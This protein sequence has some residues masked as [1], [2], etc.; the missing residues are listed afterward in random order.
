MKLKLVT[1]E[2]HQRKVLAFQFLSVAVRFAE[3]GT[4]ARSIRICKK[5]ILEMRD[6]YDRALLLSTRAAF[7]L[8]DCRAFDSGGAYVE[9]SFNTLTDR[10]YGLGTQVSDVDDL[11]LPLID[12][13]PMWGNSGR[14]EIISGA[15]FAG[16]VVRR[17]LAKI[18]NTPYLPPFRSASPAYPGPFP[19]PR[20]SALGTNEPPLDPTVSLREDRD[21]CKG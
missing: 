9:S 7:T 1:L 19:K 16:R 12:W 13:E 6:A 2:K 15:Q 21:G 11:L 10:I 18:Q 5:C 8:D 20:C 3:V 14:P 17:H 4:V